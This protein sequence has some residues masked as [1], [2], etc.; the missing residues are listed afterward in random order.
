M[1]KKK[2][3]Y[4]NRILW[5]S[6]KIYNFNKNKFSV[7]EYFQEIQKS[8]DFPIRLLCLPNFVLL[9]YLM[10]H[11][12]ENKPKT[13]QQIKHNIY[14]DIRG[15]TTRTLSKILQSIRV[16]QFIREK[17]EKQFLPSSDRVDT[18]I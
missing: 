4:N 6:W 7:T 14:E 2:K 5:F 17:N 13:L 12:Y 9:D 18:V 11:V 1:K 8:N 10:E 16:Q 15:L 3:N